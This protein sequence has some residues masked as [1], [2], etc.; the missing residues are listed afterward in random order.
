MTI[1]AFFGK[2]QGRRQGNDNDRSTRRA[3]MSIKSKS[4]IP[5][6]AEA[7]AATKCKLKEEAEEDYEEMGAEGTSKHD[8]LTKWRKKLSLTHVG[9]NTR[10]LTHR[11]SSRVAH[12]QR[13]NK[14]GSNPFQSTS[15]PMVLNTPPTLDSLD[16]QK[17]DSDSSERKRTYVRASVDCCYNQ[18]HRSPAG[19]DS[20]LLSAE[21]AEEESGIPA[22]SSTS[23]DRRPLSC[24]ALDGLVIPDVL[25]V[26]RSPPPGAY[27]SSSSQ[28]SIVSV[29]K[30]DDDTPEKISAPAAAMTVNKT[31]SSEQQVSMAMNNQHPNQKRACRTTWT[32]MSALHG[33]GDSLFTRTESDATEAKDDAHVA[34][35]EDDNVGA[36]A[37]H[38]LSYFSAY[39][40]HHTKQKQQEQH[41][42]QC[43]L[44]CMHVS[45]VASDMRLAQLDARLQAT[46][47]E[48]TALQNEVRRL[49]AEISGYRDHSRQLPS[50][51]SVSSMDEGELIHGEQLL[52]T[53][54]RAQ[55]GL[56]EY[57]EGEDDLGA[58]LERYKKQLETEVI[59]HD[60]PSNR[61]TLDESDALLLSPKSVPQPQP[62]Q[63]QTQ[64]QHRLTSAVAVTVS[65][66]PAPLL[67]LSTK[68]CLASQPT[69]SP[70]YSAINSA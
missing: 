5:S 67:A 2:I 4:P 26:L 59:L 47:Q 33:D 46:F 60:M 56:I 64:Q 21:K 32:S 9:A 66:T 6:S 38:H 37:Q 19:G 70:T 45:Q 57:L 35:A 53:H 58:A 34:P 42:Q 28:I 16:S 11:K 40:P 52:K 48:N 69:S 50:P 31:E 12:Q 68:G 15:M 29:E 49:R 17:D 30:K 1:K 23:Q 8:R 44:T 65:N 22:E 10:H 61:N 54:T 24:S 27:S 3:S 62:E 55:L 63:P 18:L 14:R 41:K 13:H 39:R 7:A 51:R 20:S 36:R 25:G 43:L